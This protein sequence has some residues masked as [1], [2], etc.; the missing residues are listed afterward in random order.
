MVGSPEKRNRSGNRSGNVCRLI[1]HWFRLK[2]QK[3]LDKLPFNWSRDRSHTQL[4]FFFFWGVFIVFSAMFLLSNKWPTCNIFTE[5]ALAILKQN[6]NRGFHLLLLFIY[7]YA[8]TT[9][10]HNFHWAFS[11]YWLWWSLEFSSSATM[12]LI[13]LLCCELSWQLLDELSLKLLQT[14]IIWFMTKYLLN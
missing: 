11:F 5:Q 13:V 2:F 9:R 4:Q 3:L 8:F 12:M 7:I 6:N 10:L 1:H 14:Y